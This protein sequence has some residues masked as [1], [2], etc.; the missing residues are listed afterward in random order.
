M[1][2]GTGPLPLSP[3]QAGTLLT[4]SLFPVAGHPENPPECVHKDSVCG[5][6]FLGLFWG[7]EQLSYPNLYQAP[8]KARKYPES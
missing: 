4:L 5:E 8:P 7:Q 6:A 1:I 2:P 3:S